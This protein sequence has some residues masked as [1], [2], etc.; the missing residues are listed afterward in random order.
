MTESVFIK[1]LLY[2]EIASLNFTTKL[3]VVKCRTKVWQHGDFNTN[4]LPESFPKLLKKSLIFRGR[5]VIGS[6]LLKLYTVTV[7]F[8][9]NVF[10][11]NLKDKVYG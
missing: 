10:H 1:A 2:I 11:N 3:Q 5:L 7:C 4:F 8:K 9:L 6:F